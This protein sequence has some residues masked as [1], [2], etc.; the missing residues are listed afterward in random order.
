M[1]N[2]AFKISQEIYEETAAKNEN[3]RKIYQDFS[4]Y[5]ADQNLWFRFTEGTFDRFM[6]T[7]KL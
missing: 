4:K 3:F 1:M 7:Q 2:E 5:R 6:Q